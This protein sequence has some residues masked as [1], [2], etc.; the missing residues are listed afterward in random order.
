M[1]NGIRIVQMT[2]REQMEA[3]IFGLQ[4]SIVS[5]LEALD[6]TAP[7]FKRD[8]WQ[9]AQ[10]GQGQS[11]VFAVP[12]DATNAASPTIL[13]KAGVNISIV[14]GTLPPAA[15]RQMR[16]NH[17]SLPI[18]PEGSAGLPF[19]AAGISLVIHPRNPHAPTAHANYRYFEIAAPINE[20]QDTSAP[21]QVIA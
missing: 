1:A 5:A 3:Y 7:R 10:G 17:A 4:D 20:G 13:E 6:P 9:R 15:V 11:C 2:M 18:P 14:H 12:A 16:V 8:S 21:A 19:Y